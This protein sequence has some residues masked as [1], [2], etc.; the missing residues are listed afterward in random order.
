MRVILLNCL[1]FPGLLLSSRMLPAQARLSASLTPSVIGRQ[2]STELRFVIEQAVRVD[3]F[4]PPGLRAFDIISGPYTESGIETTNGQTR[5]YVAI[6]YRLQP[7]KAGDIVIGPAM[8]RVNGATIKS[9]PIKLKVLSGAAAPSQAQP[10]AADPITDAAY[11]DYLLQPGEDLR[12]KIDR[13]LFI[14]VEA[15]KTSCFV[16]EPV[17]AT[18]KLYTRLKSESNIVK[19]PAFNG[20][21]VVELQPPQSG[22][23]Y[24]IEKFNGRDYNV[25]TLRKVQLYPLQPGEVQL[26]PAAVENRLQFIRAEYLRQSAADLLS[27]WMPGALPAEAMVEEKITVETKPVQ[28]T[29]KPLPEA[30]RPAS[31]TGAVGRFNLSALTEKDSL[32]TEDVGILKLLLTGEGNMLLVPAPEINWPAGISGFEPVVKD[33][34]N[35]LTVPVS[36]SRLFDYSFSADQPGSFILPAVEFSFFDPARAAYETVTTQPLKVHI[37]QRKEALPATAPVGSSTLFSWWW[38]LL[39][40]L[41]V[42]AVLLILVK[43]RKRTTAVETVSPAATAPAPALVKQQPPFIRSEALL[44]HNNPQL[45]YQTLHMELNEFLSDRLQIAPAALSK[46]S[47]TTALDEKGFSLAVRMELDALLDDISARV[48]SPLTDSGRMQDDFVRA[49]SIISTLDI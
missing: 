33:G 24:R 31:F 29:V 27:A 44:L 11:D 1:L 23:N 19:S 18:Y 17:V 15:D 3:Q 34:C 48:Y 46:K 8:A 37:L 2:E 45:F 16:G 12:K 10:A 30:G 36:G 42:P 4:T 5:R 47:I 38:L 43:K 25:Y 6:F 49:G 39:P 40:A 13:N 26:E 22:M 20:F 21:S 9:Q 32:Y 28:I 7:R 35:K 14:R 41:L